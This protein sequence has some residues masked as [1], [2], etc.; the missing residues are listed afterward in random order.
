[1]RGFACR[2][3]VLVVVVVLLALARAP[4]KA[5]SQ[6]ELAA[7]TA[8]QQSPSDA[9]IVAFLTTYPESPFR[10][11]AAAMLADLRGTSPADVLDQYGASR[12]PQSTPPGSTSSPPAPASK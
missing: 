2:S 10:D 4:A 11:K 5:D 6:A 9:A 7:W 8:I 1:M 12:A 3:L